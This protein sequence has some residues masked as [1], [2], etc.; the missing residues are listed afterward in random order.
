MEGCS[1]EKAIYWL[2]GLAI[3]FYFP[4]A[5]AAVVHSEWPNT[6][7]WKGLLSTLSMAKI[8]SSISNI[9]NYLEVYDGHKYARRCWL[10]ILVV[11]LNEI[12]WQKIIKHAC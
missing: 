7:F 6:I 11:F 12:F 4:A 9:Q 2:I 5:Y 10:Y 3:N 1:R 8:V